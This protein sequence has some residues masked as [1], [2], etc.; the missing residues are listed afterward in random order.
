MPHIILR[1]IF[2]S[3]AKKLMGLS[4]GRLARLAP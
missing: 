1:F 4:M 2:C 3:L